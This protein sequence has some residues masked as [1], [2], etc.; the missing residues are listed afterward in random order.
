MNIKHVL[1]AGLIGGGVAGAGAQ[2]TAYDLMYE[3]IGVQAAATTAPVVDTHYFSTHV[4]AMTAVDFANGTLVVPNTFTPKTLWADGI[5]GFSFV[6]GPYSSQLAVTTLYPTGTYRFDVYGGFVAAQ[7]MQ[8]SVAARFWPSVQPVFAA[9]TFNAMQALD[10]AAGLTVNFNSFTA[11]FPAN[12]ARTFLTVTDQSD[13]S[14]VFFGSVAQP[15]TS[16]VI[17]AGT[18]AAGHPYSFSLT[19]SSQLSGTDTTQALQ[20]GT[21]CS[22]D[23]TT[24]ATGVAIVPPPC[25][26]DF[27]Q[28]GGVDGADVE[29]F[30]LTWMTGVP[31]GDVNQDGGTDGADVETFIVQWQN[32]GC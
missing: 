14:T 24:I 32:G 9:S 26:A 6:D 27:N 22:F 23:L 8:Y 12:S 16:I 21:L 11:P 15:A 2:V 25:S 3:S 30:F 29:A 1:A 18:F 17:S 13:F 5:N 19:H 31:E 28:D 4:Y 20:P 10:P 7:T